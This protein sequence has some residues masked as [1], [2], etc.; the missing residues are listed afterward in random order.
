MK[1]TKHRGTYN[2]EMTEEDLNKLARLVGS[3][4]EDPRD[5]TDS[6]YILLELSR[7][8]ETYIPETV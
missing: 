8:K 1:L 3:E 5:V 4:A 7:F 6:I 2:L